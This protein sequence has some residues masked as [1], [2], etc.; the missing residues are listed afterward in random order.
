VVGPKQIPK[1]LPDVPNLVPQRYLLNGFLRR[2]FLVANIGL[3]DIFGWISRSILAE[4]TQ[5][6]RQVRQPKSSS[7]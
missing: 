5:F 4:R 3:A 2:Y 6:D 1:A 7:Q